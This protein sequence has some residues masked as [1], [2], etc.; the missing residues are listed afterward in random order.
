MDIYIYIYMRARTK[1]TDTCMHVIQILLIMIQ[2]THRQTYT[3]TH[4]PGRRILCL[5]LI[6]SS[7]K[8]AR[9]RIPFALACAHSHLLLVPRT[10]HSAAAAYS[11]KFCRWPRSTMCVCVCA[12]SLCR[13]CH[14]LKVSLSRCLL[15]H[16]HSD[17][18][19]AA[20]PRSLCVLASTA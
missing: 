3:H 17:P 15:P 8:A 10:G 9:L 6:C 2:H 12:R 16:A 18:A 7:L 20:R 19:S 14:I 1:I 4:T 13:V 11:E 5:A